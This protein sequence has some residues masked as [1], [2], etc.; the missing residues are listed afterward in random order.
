[1]IAFIIKADAAGSVI[2]ID[3]VAAVAAGKLIVFKGHFFS[4]YGT[5][6]FWFSHGVPLFH[7]YTR[8]YK[9]IQHKQYKT[10][11]VNCKSKIEKSAVYGII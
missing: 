11:R 9:D 3:A 5:A 2:F 10:I 8:F 7:F 6:L 4:T 1:M